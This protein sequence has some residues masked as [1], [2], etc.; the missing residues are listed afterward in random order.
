VAGNDANSVTLV[1]TNALELSTTTIAGTLTVSGSAVNFTDPVAAN[2]VV[3]SST[4]P[5]DLNAPVTAPGGFSSSGTNFDNTGAPITANNTFIGLSH[6]GTVN[7]AATLNAGS[8]GLVNLFGG[9][10]YTG[11]ATVSANTVTIKASTMGLD[12]ETGPTMDVV[13]FFAISHPWWAACPDWLLPVRNYRRPRRFH[14]T[15]LMPQVW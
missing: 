15:T 5:V 12:S 4:G 10:T 13:E 2:G 9:G 14:R 11:T 8:G 6:S 3:I 7:L 1:D